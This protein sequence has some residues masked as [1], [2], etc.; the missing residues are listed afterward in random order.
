MD[1]KQY[2]RKLKWR[3]SPFIKSTSM[4][5]PIIKRSQEY[6]IVKEC[7]GGWTG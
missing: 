1:R 7:I 6:E 2:Y 5:T 3:K 4:D